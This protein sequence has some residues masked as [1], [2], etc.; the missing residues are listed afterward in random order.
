LPCFC[1]ENLTTTESILAAAYEFGEEHGIRDLP[2]MLAITCNY[3][4]RSQAVYYT[5]TR[6][7][8]TGLK[9]FYKD[10]ETLT[11]KGA[12]YENLRVLVHLDHIQFDRDKDLLESDLSKYSSIMFDAS[13]L[14]FEENI[15]L[16]AEFVE[17]KSGEIVIEGAC[18]EILDATGNEH[19]DITTAENAQ[20][21]IAETGVYMIVANLGTEHRASGKELK[22]HSDA[23]C[24]IKEKIGTKIVLHGT[25][26]VPNDQIK[27]LFYDGICKVN[28]WTALERDT[29][30]VLFEDMVKNA[31][32]VAGGEMIAKLIQEGY[33]TEKCA[34]GEKLSID[35]FTMAYRNGIV[36]SEMKKIVRAYLDMWYV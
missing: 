18:D 20:R 6:D 12:P 35:N 10:I 32:K 7:S 14:P 9:L 36:F 25:S 4:H 15:K 2:I 30:P 29:S 1:S 28:I 27:N 5:H 16:T 34:T 31:S 23:A 22:Y 3:S 33:L 24:K 8:K 13:S 11:E 26:S 21:Y 19:N 17:K